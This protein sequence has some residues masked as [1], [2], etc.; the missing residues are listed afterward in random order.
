MDQFGGKTQWDRRRKVGLEGR[1]TDWWG[2]GF[3]EEN[4]R[5]LRF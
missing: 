4:C 2:S 5:D 3:W 1:K